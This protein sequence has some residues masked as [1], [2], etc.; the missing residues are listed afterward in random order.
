MESSLSI[1]SS[2][3]TVKHRLS[4][5]PPADAHFPSSEGAFCNAEEESQFLI[6]LSN[7]RVLIS[8]TD[9]PALAFSPYP[10]SIP[11]LYVPSAQHICISTGYTLFYDINSDLM[12]SG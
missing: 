11:A 4:V 3:E 12:F 5:Q 1:N 7:Q 8:A 2:R 6:G 10:G 9:G